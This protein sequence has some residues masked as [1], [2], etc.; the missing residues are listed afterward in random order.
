[1]KSNNYKISKTVSGLSAYVPGEQPQGGGWVKLNT[2]EFPYPPSPKVREAILEELGG[3]GASLRLYPQPLSDRLRKAV[4]EYYGVEPQNALAGNGSDDILNLLMRAFGD[5]NLKIAAMNP[6]YSLYPVL[7]KMQGAELLEFNFNGDYTLPLDAI[8]NSGAN[9]F[10]LT[11][12]NAP[13]GLEFDEA[14]LEEIAQNFNGLF[15]IDEAY[16]P[17]SGYTAA[18]L[19]LKYDN[20][21]VVCTSSKGWGLA[22]MRIGWAIANEK[23]IE[24]LDRVRDSYNLDRLAQV[25]GI[26][27]LEDVAYYK[28]FCRKVVETREDFEK[29]LSDNGWDYVKSRSNFVFVRPRKAG[30]SPAEAAADFFEYLK[31]QKI[32]VRFWKNDSKISDGVRVTIGTPDEMEK[33]KESALKWKELQK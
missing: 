28:K 9:V 18:K 22:G 1:M 24:V 27:A 26:A 13:L 3:D 23:I 4:A 11:N 20:I 7:A 17:F 25:A 21:L 6:S 10:I 19:A 14:V 2:N 32:L 15:V 16:A 33:F 29:F 5:E 31:S 12:P 30:L 8:F